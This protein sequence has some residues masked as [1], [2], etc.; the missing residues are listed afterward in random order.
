MV[1][2]TDYDFKF[3]HSFCEENSLMT[4]RDSAKDGG[5]ANGAFGAFKVVNQRWCA[6]APIDM[7]LEYTNEFSDL[8]DDPVD[9]IFIGIKRMDFRD[10]VFPRGRQELVLVELDKSSH[11]G[12]SEFG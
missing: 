3:S 4:R 5:C 1:D 8:I 2:L 10:F 12:F 6:H 11:D 7:C 9:A